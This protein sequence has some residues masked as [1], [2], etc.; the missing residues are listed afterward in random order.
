MWNAF[1]TEKCDQLHP[2]ASHHTRTSGLK[3]ADQTFLTDHGSVQAVR[4]ILE[5]H[6]VYD[7][8]H[9][10][11]TLG[12]KCPD[13]SPDLKIGLVIGATAGA[14][15]ASLLHFLCLSRRGESVC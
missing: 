8:K 14:Q 12:V 11:E 7:V 15:K 9:L 1:R 10:I 13:F 6:G 4:R 5:R 2:A 3:M